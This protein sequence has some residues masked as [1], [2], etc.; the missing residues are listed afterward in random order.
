MIILTVEQQI[1]AILQTISELGNSISSGQA[2]DLTP[3]K[4]QIGELYTAASHLPVGLQLVNQK[5]VATRLNLIM[6]KLEY[7][8]GILKVE[9]R[10]TAAK[11]GAFV[12]T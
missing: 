9:N 10:E 8:E 1:E 6:E 12:V 7:L 2:P 3:L 11:I 5:K 4:L